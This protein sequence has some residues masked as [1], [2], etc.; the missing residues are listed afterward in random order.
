MRKRNLRR[1]EV[2]ESGERSRK[3]HRQST[4]KTISFLCWKI[5][6]AYYVGG[7]RPD[8]EDPGEAHARALK[9][10]SKFDY[11]E[12]LSKAEEPEIDKRFRNAARRLFAQVD[13][14]F[15]RSP[16][17]ALS[18]SFNRMVHQL[19]DQWLRWLKSNLP[20]NC[21]SAPI[22]AGSDIPLEFSYLQQWSQQD[23]S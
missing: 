23:P 11:L 8:D 5:V 20:E 18:E 15:D 16:S 7:L 13:L 14:D 21:R 4:S 19:P 2:L 9:Y 17:S 22:G 1:V 12:A 3:L 6:L 10:E